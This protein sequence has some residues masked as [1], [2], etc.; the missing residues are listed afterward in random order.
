M[1]KI[2]SLVL[3]LVLMMSV[4]VVASAA[5]TTEAI[6]PEGAAVSIGEA[7]QAFSDFLKLEAFQPYF[8]AF[9]TAFGD[10]YIQLDVWLRAIG[11]AVNGFLD[12][13]I[14]NGFFN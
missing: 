13:L 9:H 11:I 2:L 10:F 5:D 14:S 6:L 4:A 8:D 7:F 12:Y 3:V 1:K